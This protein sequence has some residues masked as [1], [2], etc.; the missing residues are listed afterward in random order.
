[1]AA[2]AAAR[3]YPDEREIEA[4][5]REFMEAA[6]CLQAAENEADRQ[7]AQADAEVQEMQRKAQPRWVRS[8]FTTDRRGGYHLVAL[9]PTQDPSDSG[10]TSTAITASLPHP[11]TPLFRPPAP[12][13]IKPVCQPVSQKRFDHLQIDS[14]LKYGVYL[15]DMPTS[16]LA[17]E[18]DFVASLPEDVSR[19]NIS[20]RLRVYPPDRAFRAKMPYELDRG[21][22]PREEGVPEM[23]VRVSGLMVK[24][25]HLQGEL[26]AQGLNIDITDFFGRSK[27]MR[28]ASANS[29][30]FY[31]INPGQEDVLVSSN[32]LVLMCPMRPRPR[33]QQT[34]QANSISNPPAPPVPRPVQNVSEDELAVTSA[35]A[36]AELPTSALPDIAASSSSH[37][38]DDDKMNFSVTASEGEG[39]GDTVMVYEDRGPKHGEQQQQQQHAS[40]LARQPSVV[41]S[42]NVV[43]GAPGHSHDAAGDASTQQMAMP[44]W[45]V[46]CERKAPVPYVSKKEASKK[47]RRKQRRGKADSDDD[48]SDDDDS[49]LE[50]CGPV[51]NLAKREQI[52]RVEADLLTIQK[53]AKE[54]SEETQGLKARL[55]SGE[56]ADPRLKVRAGKTLE[57]NQ[58]LT[59]ELSTA[60]KRLEETLKQQIREQFSNPVPAPVV[61]ATQSGIADRR[62]HGDSHRQRSLF[63]HQQQQQQ[64]LNRR[65][66]DHRERDR[67]RSRERQQRPYDGRDDGGGGGDGG[68]WRRDDSRDR[69]RGRDRDR[70]RDYWRRRDD[71]RDRDRGG[72]RRY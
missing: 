16:K 25:K 63:H 35:M 24:I 40:S 27:G 57:G 11:K 38:N 45:A 12:I 58:Q 39:E 32:N 51:I 30:A 29:F 53:Q 3:S 23:K 42:A 4:A 69:D 54:I 61:P 17:T 60:Q 62:P 68:G 66:D 10:G 46:G 47:R 65:P 59:D 72:G 33:A 41:A 50:D 44:L 5:A 43:G 56:M 9:P 7:M 19:G 55:E 13:S 34:A 8:A 2:R 20:I 21:K 26:R 70:D 31:N 48:D 52:S 22:W 6:A 64:P 71:S 15:V 14:T 1:M 28:I 18:S 67:S 36:A 37:K 49:D